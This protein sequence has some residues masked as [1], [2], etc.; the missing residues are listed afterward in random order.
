V[1]LAGELHEMVDG[2]RRRPDTPRWDTGVIL[3]RWQ[4]KGLPLFS[5]DGAAAWPL[6]ISF[7]ARLRYWLEIQAARAAGPGT[8]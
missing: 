7:W 5:T 3:R 2:L 1:G 6:S 8:G 4:V